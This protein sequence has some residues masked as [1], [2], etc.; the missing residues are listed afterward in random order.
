MAIPEF[1]NQSAEDAAR[2]AAQQA[3]APYSSGRAQPA[4]RPG[5]GRQYDDPF[6]GSTAAHQAAVSDR[7]TDYWNP[8]NQLERMEQAKPV[9]QTADY[10]SLMR[11]MPQR[12]SEW[13]RDKNIWNAK[14]GL[15][16]DAGRVNGSWAQGR[17][18]AAL[19]GAGLEKQMR[20]GYAAEDQNYA[21]NMIS[22]YQQALGGRAGVTDPQVQRETADQVARTQ[23]GQQGLANAGYAYGY[24]LAAD[25]ADKDRFQQRYETDYT[26]WLTRY[27]YDQ[28]YD[29]AKRGS[30]REDAGLG[31]RLLTE[32][33][34]RAGTSLQQAQDNINARIEMARTQGPQAYEALMQELRTTGA[35]IGGQPV[36]PTPIPPPIPIGGEALAAQ[37]AED[38]EAT[39]RRA[40]E[41]TTRLLADLSE[42]D[43]KRLL[44]DTGLRTRINTVIGQ[45]SAAKSSAPVIDEAVSNLVQN[46][47]ILGRGNLID[48]VTKEV[49]QIPTE[50]LY[51]EDDPRGGLQRMGQRTGNWFLDIGKLF[52]VDHLFGD[53]PVNY[54][55]GDREQMRIGPDGQVAYYQPDA[56]RT[57]G[58]TEDQLRRTLPRF[59]VDALNNFSVEQQIAS[60]QQR[61]Q[62]LEVAGQT[63]AADAARAQIQQIRLS[64]N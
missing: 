4:P 46:A 29:I 62:A 5:V 42:D 39:R 26:N 19:A 48:P 36:P 34:S 44:A 55:A 57:V 17:Q 11:Q 41:I 21:Q 3:G 58:L 20:D 9:T 33:Q 64:N 28:N 22:A 31:S 60:L 50:P 16:A 56:D 52:G 12:T 40:A 23:L 13:E 49:L 6:R 32:Q 1:N 24:D 38:N 43:Q 45:M 10:R 47:M 51:I 7:P 30:D 14:V 63:A 25:T 61:A 59:D 35:L 18:A 54:F 53:Q 15:A 37:N 8:V 27:L 2:R